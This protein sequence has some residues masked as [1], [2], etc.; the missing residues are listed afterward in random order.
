MAD[1]EDE[2]ATL[3]NRL[4]NLE[5][6]AN[7]VFNWDA[8]DY[9]IKAY[10]NNRTQEIQNKLQVL[11]DRYK[12]ASSRYDKEVANAQWEKEYALKERQVKI[13]EE[14]LALKDWQ[15]RNWITSTVNPNNKSSTN[16]WDK[17]QVTTMTDAEVWAAVD[18]LVTMLNNWQL[19]NAQCWVWLQRYYF[20]ML[21][22]NISGISDYDDK[23]ALINEWKD[24]IPKKWDL[25][26]L[27]S[28]SKPWNWHIWVVIWVDKNWTVQY[29]DWN[30]SF[31]EQWEG[32]EK[33]Q[34]HFIN[35]NDSKVQ[36]FR[37]INK[38]WWASWMSVY[39]WYD[40]DETWYIEELW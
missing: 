12:Y 30:G 10:I 31:N 4:Q 27:S 25:I 16:S 1:I 26:I 18:E 9:L 36:W 23:L 24:Y 5:K 32:S 17:Y 7:K 6:E 38:S 19:W 28:K 2:M 20:P 8:P 29:L 35:I 34:I 15:I 40:A 21:W 37:N 39:P 33:A 3:T 11:S 14:E 13:Q 22:I